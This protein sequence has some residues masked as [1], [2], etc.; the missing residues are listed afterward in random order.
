MLGHTY[1]ESVAEEGGR[2]TG[3]TWTEDGQRRQAGHFV[4]VAEALHLLFRE[5]RSGSPPWDTWLSFWKM[6]DGTWRT[7]GKVVVIETPIPFLLDARTWEEGGKRR[8]APALLIGIS[9]SSF[10]W[11]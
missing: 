1:K 2:N 5:K 3:R 8:I 10:C 7:D 11:S 6:V 4:G 9:P